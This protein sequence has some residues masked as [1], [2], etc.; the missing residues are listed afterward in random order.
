MGELIGLGLRAVG[1]SSINIDLVP[2]KVQASRTADKQKPFFIGA[3]ALFLGGLAAWAVLNFV[4]AGKAKKEADSMA[5]QKEKLESI[6]NPIESQFKK[7]D[8]L[9]NLANQYTNTEDDRTFW[10]DLFQEL[11]AGLSSE[12]IWITDMEPL[13]DY[14]ATSAD[15]KGKP[16]VKDEYP[17]AAYGTS[18]LQPV[19]V[20]VPKGKAVKGAPV[21]PEPT[22]TANAVRIKGFWRENPRSGNIVYDLLK[23]LR[24]NPQHFRFDAMTVPV[25]DAKGVVKGKAE[26]VELKDEQIVKQ[27]ESAP[28]ASDFAA[29]FELI[30]PLSREVPIK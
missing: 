20:E 12:R 29:P 13:F 25:A 21:G 5:D 23:K 19:K 9:V 1:K 7:Q 4:A 11:K 3:A 30:I 26:L 14:N 10:L 16:I 17:T 24:A 2:T 6:Y 28:V 15:K 27:L 8:Q 18:S 22:P